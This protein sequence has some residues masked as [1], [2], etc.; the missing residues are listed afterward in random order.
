M[1]RAQGGTSIGN[2]NVVRRQSKPYFTPNKDDAAEEIKPDITQD[3][4]DLEQKQIS[5]TLFSIN[6]IAQLDMPRKEPSNGKTTLLTFIIVCY[7]F[8]VHMVKYILVD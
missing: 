7:N 6:P 1:L 3:M 8:R 4:M 2:V 5:Q